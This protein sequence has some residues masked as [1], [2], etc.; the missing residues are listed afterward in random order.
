MDP[1]A[2]TKLL[3]KLTLLAL[4]TDISLSSMITIDPFEITSSTLQIDTAQ[5]QPSY[6]QMAVFQFELQSMTVHSQ[7]R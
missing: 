6:S 5:L 4:N 2:I 1:K 7:Q 3:P